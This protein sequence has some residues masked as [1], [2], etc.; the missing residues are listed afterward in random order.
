LKK[1]ATPEEI[2]EETQRESIVNRPH[3]LAGS[4]KRVESTRFNISNDSINLG[5]S[6]VVPAIIKLFM[7]ALDNPIDVAIKGHCTKID[8]K[9]DEKSIRVKDDGYGVSTEKSEG[10]YVLYKAFCKYNTSSN[11]REKKGMGQ[12]G[13]NG[14]G[15]KLCTTLSTM[16][17]VT[18][19]DVKGR[20]KL[21]ATENN[22]HH[23]TRKLA[24]SG[25]TGVE[26]YF[27][28]D[29]SIFDTDKLDDEHINRMYEYTL[30]Q[31]L[32]YPDI[33]FTFNGKRVRLRPKHFMDMVSPDYVL[34]ETENY[35]VA[36]TVNDTGDFKQLSYVNGLEVSKGGTHITAITTPLVNALRDKLVR[37]YKS[38]KPVD[39]RNKLQVVMVAKNMK[40]IDWE[41]Q[42]KDSI[43]S[44]P[45]SLKDYF[46]ETDIDKLALK[47]YRNGPILDSIVDYFKIKEE[48]NKKKDLQ[49]LTK[50]VKIK[51]DK[52]LPSIKTNK[53]IFI[54]E[55]QSATGGLL[56]PIG[57]EEA[58]F[59]SLKGKPLNAYSSSTQKFTGNKELSELFQII[60]NEEY[61]YIIPATDQDLDG[62]HIRG[63][64]IGFVH[65]Y[66]PEY[67]HKLGLLNT[68]V[69]V[70]KK[71]KKI[72]RWYY[73][74]KDNVKINKG[75][76]SH[77]YKGLGTWKVKDL[78][79]IIE[80]EGLDKMIQQ[81]DFDDEAEKQMEEWL[82][83]DSTPRKKYIKK[84][85]FNI[86]KL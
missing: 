32:T 66:L 24:K 18:S 41:G 54:T 8:I 84:N 75:E 64:I 29:F 52:Y 36:I 16:F 58:A 73:S 79:H 31:S 12:K 14:I 47:V 25:R 46:A 48:Y 60:R 77:Y 63:L 55:G 85:D 27:E 71:N 2:V 34:E 35:F 30:M 5:E 49:K 80:K 42:V 4:V 3:N 50:K 9:V 61:E 44:S 68:P 40:N 69:V 82:G 76:T 23:K 28:P 83:D 20:L 21:T 7:E 59:Y 13:V 10:E 6:S 39:I 65:R 43:T 38:I 33:A 62:I 45:A 67:K 17:E 15:V 53:Y 57:R 81:L 19:E 26:I 37:K 56:D 72:V 51:S 22:L 78:E 74:L 70:V 11:Y 1:Q 86:A